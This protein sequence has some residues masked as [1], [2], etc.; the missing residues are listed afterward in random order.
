M[1]AGAGCGHCDGAIRELRINSVDVCGLEECEAAGG[2]TT[3]SQDVS[4]RIMGDGP[5]DESDALLA[6]SGIGPETFFLLDADD[7]RVA[8]TVTG[9]SG[10]HTCRNG[11]DFELIPEETLPLGTYTVVLLLEDLDWPKVGRADTQTWEGKRAFVRE[12]EVVAPDEG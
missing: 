4:V 2:V 9:G 8:A 1:L 3:V 7:Q 11:V 5:T 10:G 6:D 12:L